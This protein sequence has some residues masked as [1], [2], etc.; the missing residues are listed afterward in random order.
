MDEWI[1]MWHRY[2]QENIIQP[3]KNEILPFATAKMIL[4]ALCYEK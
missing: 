3:E 2:T 1:K 4:R